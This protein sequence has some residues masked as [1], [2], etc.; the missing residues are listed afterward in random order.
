MCRRCTQLC[1]FVAMIACGLLASPR[2]AADTLTLQPIADT[3][4]FSIAPDNNLGGAGFFNAGTAGNGYLNRALLRFDLTI[5]PSGSQIIGVSLT[6]D[7][8]RE[9]ASDRQNSLFSLRR[10][11]VP[12]GE[13]TQVPAEPNSPG[14]G[15]L[16]VTGEATW[17]Q[18]F[19]GGAP[20]TIPGGRAGTDFSAVLSSTA[21]VYGVGDP[22]EFESTPELIADLQNWADN[23]GANFGWLMMTES[24]DVRR[25]AR[26]FASRESG[27]GPTLTVEFTPVPEPSSLALL[28]LSAG[29]LGWVFRRRRCQS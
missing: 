5:I 1:A 16:A 25:T 14:L 6:M 18:R 24:E 19:V 7:V 29:V 28:G 8:I 11:F 4:L 21:F 9:P 10:V 15:A 20:W 23:P 3:T 22:V 13:G 26:G 12:W 2:V 17:N 27:F